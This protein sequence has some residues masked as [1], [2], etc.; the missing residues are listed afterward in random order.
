M[1]ARNYRSL[2]YKIMK[3]KKKL[4]NKNYVNTVIN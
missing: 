3:L 4:V 2:R 1:N